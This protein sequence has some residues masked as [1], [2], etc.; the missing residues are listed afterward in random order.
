MRR[1]LTL[2]ELLIVVGIIAVLTATGMGG[3]MGV[4]RAAQR[5]RGTELVHNFQVAL[6]MA[7]QKLDNWPPVIVK[8]S[9]GDGQATCEVGVCLG[10]PVDKGGLGVFSFGSCV[11]RGEAMVYAVDEIEEFGVLSPWGTDAARQLAATDDLKDDAR[12]PTGGTIADHRLRFAVDDDYDGITEVRYTGG[13]DAVS[14]RA[15]ACVWCCG[16]DGKFNTKDDIKSWARG[17]EIKK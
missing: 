7:L 15:S 2:L 16:Y 17:Q 4:V 10:R 12:L 9:R 11:Q 6:E 5:S 13:G 1:G 8:A 14:V 3:Y